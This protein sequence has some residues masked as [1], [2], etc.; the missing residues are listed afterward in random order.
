MED[1]PITRGRGRPKKTIG[2]TIRKD[3]TINNL[4]IT[5]SKDRTC[6]HRLI[7]IADLT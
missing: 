4:I 3:V 6:W 1:N 7:Y 5:M 2:E